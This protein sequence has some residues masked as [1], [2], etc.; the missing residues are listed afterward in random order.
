MIS[1]AEIN[2]RGVGSA[3]S[4]TGPGGGSEGQRTGNGWLCVH[5]ALRYH[6]F[7]VNATGNAKRK[8]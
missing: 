7:A 4:G 5:R 3:H 8:A 6:D 2:A 1:L